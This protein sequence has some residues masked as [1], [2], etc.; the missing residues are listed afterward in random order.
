MGV[1]VENCRVIVVDKFILLNIG[2]IFIYS[3][4][5]CSDCGML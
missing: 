3:L 1:T 5:V 4:G 2:K